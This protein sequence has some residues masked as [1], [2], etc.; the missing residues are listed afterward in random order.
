MDSS[1]QNEQDN[2]KAASDEIESILKKYDLC[3]FYNLCNQYGG[4][5]NFSLRRYSSMKWL[6]DDNGRMIGTYIDFKIDKNN[7]N[8]SLQKI[9]NCYVI[10]KYFAE[11]L[12]K[13]SEHMQEL[14]NQLVNKLNLDRDEL[15]G[16][17]HSVKI[18]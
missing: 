1:T 7:V 6:L 11:V 3:G 16:I 15:E 17:I 10:S 2:L 5:E 8:D 18:H 13:Q 14:N 4:T 12:F 9:M